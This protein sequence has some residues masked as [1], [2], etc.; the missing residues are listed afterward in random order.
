MIIL[1]SS[2]ICLFLY[3][4]SPSSILAG[5]GEVG[6]VF[7]ELSQW[8]L[9]KAEKL[10]FRLL[11]EKVITPNILVAT[12]AVQSA[13]GFHQE[14]YS[15]LHLAQTMSPDSELHLEFPNIVG[16]NYYA[17]DF[18]VIESKHFRINFIGKDQIVAEL[19]LDVLEKAYHRLG[20]LLDV[21]PAEQKIKIAV[22]IYPNPIGLARATGLSV[23]EIRASGTIAVCKY[24]RLMI[25]S[26]LS[27]KGGYGWADTIVH[28]FIHLLVSKKSHNNIPIWLHEGIAKFFE[29]AWNGAPGRGLQ[30]YSEELLAAAVEK[31]ELISFDAMHPSMAKLPSQESAALAFAEVF[32][33]I[34]W[35]YKV[36]G[37]QIIAQLLTEVGKHGDLNRVLTE[38]LTFKVSGLEKAWRKYLKTRSFQRSPGVQPE[39]VIFQNGDR[40]PQKQEKYELKHRGNEKYTRLGALLEEQTRYKAALIEYGKAWTQTQSR[41]SILAYRYGRILLREKRISLAEQVIAT[42]LLNYPRNYDLRMLAARISKRRGKNSE[43]LKNLSYAERQNPF[44]PQIYR[45]KVDIFTEEKNKKLLAKAK[46]FLRMAESSQNH[47]DFS[48]LPNTAWQEAGLLIGKGKLKIGKKS[49]RLPQVLDLSNLA[50]N[51]RMQLEQKAINFQLLAEGY[52]LLVYQFQ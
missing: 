37:P 47:N 27:T 33:V 39:K 52:P 49:F 14:A 10:A 28:E 20:N 51:E 40:T 5:S 18:Q 29:T 43:A 41:P 9:E 1:R 4:S 24:H 48:R 26:P 12:A 44:N 32:T 7:K 17:V 21:F 6:G 22:D 11:T 46:R 15:L 30:S 2:F 25:I 16:P 23:G 34:E 36:H 31:N 38:L 8:Q 3:L 35:L 50:P 45:T 42:G 13:Q 19:A